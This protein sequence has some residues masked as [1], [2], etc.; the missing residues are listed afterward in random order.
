MGSSKDSIEAGKAKKPQYGT[1]DILMEM[2]LGGN[3]KP[4]A[5]KKVKIIK[6]TESFMASLLTE[7][8]PLG[9]PYPQSH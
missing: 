6:N 3:S 4:T 8:C 9:S 5:G 2:L 1:K 7:E